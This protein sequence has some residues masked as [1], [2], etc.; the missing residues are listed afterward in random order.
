MIEQ[1]CAEVQR[2]AHQMRPELCPSICELLSYLDMKGKLLGTASGNLAPV[3]WLKLEKAGLKERFKF[4]SFSFPLEL[5]VDILRRG[6]EMAR[7][8]RGNATSVYIVGDTPADIEAAHAVKT[9][10]IALATGIYAFEELIKF[11]PDACFGC[12]TDMLAYT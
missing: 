9:P 8:H 4:G 7:Q 12:G 3:G 1:I 11:A 2:N 10:V 6:I 5:R